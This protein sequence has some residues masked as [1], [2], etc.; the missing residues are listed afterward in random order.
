MIAPGEQ[1]SYHSDDLEVLE[2]LREQLD[3]ARLEY[4]VA[5]AEFDVMV[6]N[7]PSGITQPDGPLRIHKAGQASRAALE[8][9]MR[10]LKRF[11]G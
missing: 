11:A 6:R 4:T 10:A 3:A 7:V 2:F 9:Y 5:S 8:N 1:M